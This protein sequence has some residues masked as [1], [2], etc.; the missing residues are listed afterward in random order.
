MNFSVSHK[1]FLSMSAIIVAVLA[2]SVTA[3]YALS[4]T[5]STFS[6]LVDVETA[7]ARHGHIAKINLL[8]CRRNEKDMLYNDDSSL[9]K[10]I[11]EFSQKVIDEA[12]AINAL[13]VHTQNTELMSAVEG[14]QKAASNYKNLF[15]NASVVAAGQERIVAGLPMRKAGNEEEKLLDAL[16]DQLDRRIDDVKDTALQYTKTMGRVQFGISFFVVAWGVMVALF[17]ISSIVRPLH[18]LE[19]RMKELAEGDVQTEVPFLA[20]PDEIGAMA[21]AVQ[22]FKDNMVE[23]R[24]LAAEQEKEGQAKE[25]RAQKIDELSKAFEMQVGDLVKLLSMAAANMQTTSQT[26]AASA[27]ETRRQS[28]AV[29]SA[30]E[31]TS[32][33]VQVVAAATEELTASIGEINNQVDQAS[34]IT[35]KASSD[36]ESANRTVETLAATAQKIGEVVQLIQN[37]A[38][39]TNLLALNATIEAARAGEA[40]KGFAVVASEVKSLANQ[41]GKATEDIERQI[42][43]IQ[44][45]TQKAVE[46]IRGICGTLTEIQMSS[47]RIASAVSEQSS[48]TNEISRNVQQAAQGTQQVTGSITGVT[49]AAQETGVAAVQMLNSANDLA[50]QSE[51]LRNTV[52]AF[53]ADVRVA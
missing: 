45:E 40:G 20:R 16:L 3:N 25:R 14:F 1:I 50:K 6:S 41:T 21:A 34:K 11:D 19:L 39:Q 48:A 35:D 52:D 13:V 12:T 37:I 4:S 17:L 27:E 51:T 32:G 26:L 47:T 46:A 42:T 8:Q 53:L 30:S 33:S 38:G 22:V 9:I 5:A 29:A 18:K 31:E 49:K 23:G 36:G 2:L 43:T 28:V 24:R 10:T 44:T 15:Q 7:M